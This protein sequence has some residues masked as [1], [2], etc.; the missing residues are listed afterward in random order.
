MWRILPAL[1]STITSGLL[2]GEPCSR[3]TLLR[4]AYAIMAMAIATAS[5]DSTSATAT[6]LR[7]KAVAII[8]SCDMGVSD[9][10]RLFGL[11]E[12]V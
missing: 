8:D 1:L 11:P 7:Q 10:A 6:L 12:T 2:K 9:S 4:R 3:L 5:V